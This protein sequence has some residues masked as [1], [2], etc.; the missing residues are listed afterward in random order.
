MDK[1]GGVC[2]RNKVRDFI[3]NK[4][5]KAYKKPMSLR[6]Q[7]SGM[8]IFC[9]VAAVCIQAVVMIAM[10]MNQYITREREDTLYILESDNVKIDNIFQYVEE[11]AISIQHNVGLRSFFRSSVYS[12]ESVKED[13]ESVTNLFSERNQLASSRP[14]VEKIYLYNETDKSISN[15]YY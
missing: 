5:K 1:M 11:I 10:T 4:M 13:L 14:F 7:L 6:K 3:E 8:I 12:D 15:L 2:M 9:C